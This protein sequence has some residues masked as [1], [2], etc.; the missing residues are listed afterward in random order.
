[1]PDNGDFAAQKVKEQFERAHIERRNALIEDCAKLFEL[2][3]KIWRPNEIVDAIRK[4]K[5]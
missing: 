3:S 2:S 5:T 1:M 4:L